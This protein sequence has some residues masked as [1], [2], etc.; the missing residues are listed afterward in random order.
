M[1]KMRGNK[2]YLCCSWTALH[3]V[4][5]CNGNNDIIGVKKVSSSAYCPKS[6]KKRKYFTS[7]TYFEFV[8]NGI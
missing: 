2:K 7:F 8:S 5:D 1:N 4:N 3:F 6:E